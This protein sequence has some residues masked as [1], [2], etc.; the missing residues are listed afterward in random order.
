MTGTIPDYDGTTEPTSGKSLFAQLVN[1]TITEVTAS[2]LS[3][4]TRI[5][6]C[7]FRACTGLTSVTIPDSVTS[8]GGEAFADCHILPSITIPNSV[9]TID[10]FAFKDCYGLISITISDSMTYIT[11]YMCDTCQSLVSITIP[12]GIT[13]IAGYA[14]RSCGKKTADGTTYTI[15][16]VAPPTIQSGTFQYAKINK[17]IVPKGSGDT[18]KAATNWSV[19]ADYIEEAAE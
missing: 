13:R 1:R 6:I 16:A 4:V 15:L 12:G 18:Y 8:I 10:S 5:G 14:F 17:I 19:L 11:D 9:T 7:A 3:G 2:D